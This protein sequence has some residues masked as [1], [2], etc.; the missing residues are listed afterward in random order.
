[1]IGYTSLHLYMKISCLLYVD[2]VRVLDSHSRGDTSISITRAH[3]WHLCFFLEYIR[4][5][6]VGWLWN[7]KKYWYL[8]HSLFVKKNRRIVDSELL[9]C[10]YSWGLSEKFHFVVILF[11]FPDLGT[12]HFEHWFFLL[13]RV[14][15]AWE[16]ELYRNRHFLPSIAYR[17]GIVR[18]CCNSYYK[19][20]NSPNDQVISNS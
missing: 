7:S 19:L 6:R 15:N 9:Y 12:I 5:F 3:T 20:F 18:S 1:M 13:L 16:Y 11:L 4:F 17:V 14:S 2:S 8:E 10:S